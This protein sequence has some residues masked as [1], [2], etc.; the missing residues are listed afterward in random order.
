[1]LDWFAK[2]FA[3]AVVDMRHKALEEGWFGKVVTPVSQAVS[4]DSEGE[5][6]PAEKLGWWRRDDRPPASPVDLQD[7]EVAA[8]EPQAPNRGIDL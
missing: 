2:G 5:Q 3:A 1:M 7:R 6:S 8:K 4:I